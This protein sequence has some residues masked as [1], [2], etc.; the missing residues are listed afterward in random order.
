MTLN[1][2]AAVAAG[3]VL[4]MSGCGAKE[5]PAGGNES[6]DV[7]KTADKLPDSAEA[8]KEIETE[9]EMETETETETETVAGKAA[10]TGNEAEKATEK[11]T[12]AAQEAE[13]TAQAPDSQKDAPAPEGSVSLADY[14]I[15][16]KGV[17][18][19]LKG[20]MQDYAALI[21]D[22]DQF[23]EARSC[24]EAGT[25]KVY[26]YGGIVIYTYITNGA[27]IVSLIEVEGGEPLKS[28]IH[29]G[30]T[31][32]EVIAAY[33]RGYSEEGDELL[34]KTGDMTIG[35]QMTGGKVSFMEI[36]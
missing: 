15:T 34:Y 23:S 18:I 26:T 21:G 36:Y 17:S 5:A 2:I 33:G 25:D 22:P 16:V 24:T 32:D 8:G 31:K 9:K 30:S 13:S 28:G 6:A 20:N 35:L 1:A 4:C 12:E 14:A 7:E 11:G 10:E 3:I 19:P 27:D 29:I